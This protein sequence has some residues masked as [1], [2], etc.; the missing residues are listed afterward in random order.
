MIRNSYHSHTEGHHA[1][2]TLVFSGVL[3]AIDKHHSNKSET[4]TFKE[5]TLNFIHNI[6][7]TFRMCASTSLVFKAFK[8]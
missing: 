2:H 8:R 6:M 7:Q 3:V 4:I 5:I 1:K